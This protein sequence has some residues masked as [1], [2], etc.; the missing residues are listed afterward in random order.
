MDN[1]SVITIAGGGLNFALKKAQT[2]IPGFDEITAGGL[3]LHRPTL[4]CGSAG[5][6]KTLFALEFL[7]NGILK[8]DE[9]GVFVSF[10]ENETELIENVA[11]LG[12][13]LKGLTEQGKLFIDHVHIE[14][15]EIEETGEFNLEGLF[16]RIE[17]AARAVGARRIG[18]DSIEAL[19][20]GF[21][22]D[23]LL[24]AEIR[25]LFRWLKEK[26]L[27][28]VIT[29]EKGNQMLTRHGLEEYISDCV[30]FLDNRMQGQVATRRMR[31]IKYRGTSHGTNEYPF[32]LTERGISV[33]PITALAMDYEVSTQRVSTG[34][35]RLDTMLGGSGYYRGS[36]VL[37]SGTAGTGKSSLGAC[38]V[39]AACG[40]GEQAIYFSFEEAPKQIIRNMGSIGIDLQTPVDQ[41]LLT[42]HSVRVTSFGL[43]MHLA[44]MLRMIDEIK[45]AVVVIDPISN[46]SSVAVL[47]DVKEMLARIIDYMKMLGITAVFTDL[48]HT[49]SSLEA[50]EAGISSLM[51]TWILLRDIELNGERNRGMYV[52]KSRGMSHSNQIRE[53]I[54]SREGISLKDV[55]IGPG[56]VLTGTARVV[57]EAAEAEEQILRQRKANNMRQELKRREKALQMRIQELQD[58]FTAEKEEIEQELAETQAKEKNLAYNTSALAAMRGQDKEE[59]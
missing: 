19:F 34:I 1:S 53:F 29:G 56:G 28:A 42:F 9:P 50:T 58:A 6:G 40:R 23:S 24:R 59:R 27:T 22:S 13:D 52:L 32:L 14:R 49:G 47:E 39:S 17:A 57:Q 37:I 36:S 44:G 51:D 16:I 33:V 55:Y 18:I 26:N 15:S 4:V 20:S 2:G 43:E 38:F 31:I 8:F 5:S 46:L 12:W 11:S 30:L 25:R 7:V 54:I 45:P 21:S 35:E 10:E 41:G 48:S 3:P